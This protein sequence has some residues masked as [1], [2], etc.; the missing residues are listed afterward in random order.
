MLETIHKQARFFVALG[1]PRDTVIS[2]LKA[3][4]PTQADEAEA[5][6]EAARDQWD[7][8]E[9]EL[10]AQIDRDERAVASEHSLDVSI[11]E[12]D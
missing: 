8:S 4:F 12:E 3:G 2:Q 11:H 6:Y 10:N 5:A 7:K 9:R 1:Y